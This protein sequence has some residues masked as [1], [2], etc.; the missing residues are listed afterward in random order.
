[1]NE[2]RKIIL[3]TIIIMLLLGFVWG[4]CEDRNNQRVYVMEPLECL[5]KPSG[6]TSNL[7][8]SNTTLTIKKG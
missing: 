1:M 7:G 2:E 4:F 6:S 3:G 5:T 8:H